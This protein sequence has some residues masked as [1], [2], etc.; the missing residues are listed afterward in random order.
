[1]NDEHLVALFFGREETAIAKTKSAYG[2]KLFRIAHGILRNDQDAEECE[3]DTYL[4]AWSSIPPVNPAKYFCAYLGK[5]TRNNAINTYNKLHTKKRFAHIV[6][7]TEELEQCIPNP[8]EQSVEDKLALTE[9]MNGFLAELNESERDLF[10]CRYWYGKTIEELAL[11][12]FFSTS[13]VKSMLFRTRNKLRERL[14]EED[15]FV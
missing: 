5:I 4:S 3:N 1:M 9:I 8:T 15:I 11:Q 13:K 6:N 10:I 2:K 14:E 7:L 12:F